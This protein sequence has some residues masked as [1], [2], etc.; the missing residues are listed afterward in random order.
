MRL[1]FDVNGVPREL[2]ID[3]GARLIDILRL[4]LGLTGTKEG[5]GEGECGACTVL[6]D[7]KA[8]DSCLMLAPQVQGKQVLTVEGLAQDGQLG[9]LQRQ[10]I[11][12][13]AVQCG[14]C[15]PGMLMSAKALLQAVPHPREDEIRTALAGNLC[16]CTGYAAIIA[17]VRAAAA[18]AP[19][20]APAV[21]I[22]ET[23]APGGPSDT[24]SPGL[25]PP[26]AD[27]ETERR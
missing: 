25:A 26:L 6:V 16:R 14:F 7:G 27:E 9:E 4:H 22:I 21:D 24:P 20:P 3:A 18:V 13:G 11:E 8:V 19:A 15:T 1:A 17:A 23:E 2:D 12:H 5:C 10:F